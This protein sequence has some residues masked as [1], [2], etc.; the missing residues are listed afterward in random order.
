M[1]KE[2]IL[3]LER[4][5]EELRA[6]ALQFGLDPGPVEFHVVPAE[7]IYEK[8][9]YGL[10]PYPHWT[11]GAGYYRSK[12]TYDYGL[13]R[14]YELVFHANPA[15]A[16]LLESNR[17]I[18]QK[19]VIAHVYGHTDFYRRNIWYR[20]AVP[21]I[22]NSVQANLETVSRLEEEHGLEAVEQ[23]LDAALC[24]A[25]HC[26]IGKRKSPE[27]VEHERLRPCE[28]QKSEYSDL[29]ELP[30]CK[31]P[32]IQHKPRQI[33]PEPERDI[34][35]FVAEHSPVLEDWQR[36]LLYIV[37]GEHAYY[38]PNIRT[39]IMN[40]GWATFWHERILENAELT[41]DEH[42]QFRRAHTG[43]LASGGKYSVNPYNVGYHVWR[44]IERRRDEGEEQQTWYGEQKSRAAGDGLQ[45]CFEVAA[46]YSDSS[47]IRESLT[48]KLVQDLDLYRYAHTGKPKQGQWVVQQSE[49]Q[50]VR[51][52]M[53]DDLLSNGIPAVL[54]VDGNYKKRGELYLKHDHDS[55]GKPLDLAYSELVLEHLCRLW[56]RSVYIE[57]VNSESVTQVICHE[58]E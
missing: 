37:R 15:Q 43:V 4:S 18:E 16:Y 56:G 8:A 54:I 22:V 26:D 31:M 34:L 1:N 45:K 46:D 58:A 5:E 17:L 35:G 28:P 52:A 39:K 47:F 2:D 42:V 3:E 29:W 53:A 13:Q 40:E 48:E 7:G 10:G 9:S 12:T 20:N 21:D 57:T 36:T 44:E 51:D 27:Q 23:I 19:L 25:Q 55:D 24:L 11:H 50:Q 38:Q 6:V 32:S 14:I 41:P 30:G 33:P 49:W